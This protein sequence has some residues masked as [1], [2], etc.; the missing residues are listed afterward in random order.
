MT[1]KLNDKA[2]KNLTFRLPD[3]FHR[4][5]AQ[6]AVNTGHTLNGLLI[7]IVRGHLMDCGYYPSVIKSFS[8]RLFDVTV[9][10]LPFEE[11]TRYFCSKFTI[12]EY[13]PL[14]SKTK[15]EYFIGIDRHLASSGDPFGVVNDV[16]LGLLNFYNRQGLEI[17]QLAWQKVATEPNHPTSLW[18]DNW[19]FIGAG[20]TKNIDQFLIALARNH[21]KDQL[22]VITG[23][24]QDKRYITVGIK[25]PY[26][27]SG[28]TEFERWAYSS[29]E[30]WV[31]GHG[32]SEVTEEFIQTEYIDL[33]GY[34]REQIDVETYESLVLRCLSIL[35]GLNK[36]E[37]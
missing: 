23:E 12:E 1:S 29:A 2:Y 7:N 10:P 8:G 18:Q 24:A 13:D 32:K 26:S 16:G 36:P 33:P 31:R 9:K 27:N 19:R 37:M 11:T 28:E 30:S 20:T 14:F 25:R 22:L 3:E 35:R 6:Q 15:A 21:W 17:D 4:Q 5:L 34:I